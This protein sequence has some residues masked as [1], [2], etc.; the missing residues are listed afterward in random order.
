[1]KF[2]T[3]ENGHFQESLLVNMFSYQVKIDA[4]RAG[5]MASM[6]Y[7]S[8]HQCALVEPKSQTRWGSLRVSEPDKEPEGRSPGGAIYRGE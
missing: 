5:S 4:L 8:E 3:C 1:M 6:L 2:L 7:E